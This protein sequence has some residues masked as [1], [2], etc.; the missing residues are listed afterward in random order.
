MRLAAQIEQHG[1]G[2]LTRALL[3]TADC[4]D[5]RKA[6]KP[7][8]GAPL[9]IMQRNGLRGL[10]CAAFGD[11]STGR[12]RRHSTAGGGSSQHSS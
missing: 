10:L 3:L 1:H 4:T 6:Q 12:N 8:L 9:A 2:H 11:P 5:R 7:D